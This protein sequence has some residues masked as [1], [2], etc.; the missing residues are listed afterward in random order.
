MVNRISLR[1]SNSRT[2]YEKRKNVL[3]II[4]VLKFDCYIPQE[5]VHQDPSE[6]TLKENSLSNMTQSWMDGPEASSANDFF[7]DPASLPSNG[8]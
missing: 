4:L 5:H 8:C 1:V 6:K 2:N 7:I 3:I